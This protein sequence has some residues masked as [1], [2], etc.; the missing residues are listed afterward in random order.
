MSGQNV[1]REYA[2]WV[3]TDN[4]VAGIATATRVAAAGGLRHFVTSVSA[5]FSEANA[6][7]LLTLEQGGTEIGR[8]Y[9]HNQLVLALNSPIVIEPGNDAILE[10]AAGSGTGAVTLTGYTL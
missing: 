6:G 10:L 5:S 4:A 2:S 7:V 3:E 9:V 8:W 1:I